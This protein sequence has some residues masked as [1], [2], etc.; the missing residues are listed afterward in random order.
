[1]TS[2]ARTNISSGSKWE[3]MIGYSRAVRVG[4]HI[5]VSGTTGTDEH[6]KVVGPNDPYAQTKQALKNIETALQKAGAS[7][8]DVVR[9]RMFVTNAKEWEKYGKAH[10][11]YFGEIRPATCIVEV[12]ALISP[13]MMVEIEADAIVSA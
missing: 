2:N 11:E 7:L 1:M 9:T 3:P 13:E 4:Q 5:F 12:K 6:G 10:G 8:G